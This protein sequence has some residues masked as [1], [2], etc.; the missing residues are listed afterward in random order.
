MFLNQVPSH[1]INF[2]HEDQGACIDVKS[3]LV[4]LAP[5]PGDV[6]K[7]TKLELRVAIP[8]SDKKTMLYTE[9]NPLGH[10]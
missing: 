6:F 9:L 4:S 5:K 2:V 7:C 8:L 3:K 1:N 10:L